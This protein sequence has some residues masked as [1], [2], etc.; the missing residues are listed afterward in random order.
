MQTIQ[1]IYS[2]SIRPLG[3]NER[4][5]L[6]ALILE[7]VTQG[8]KSSQL[9]AEEKTLARQRLRQFAGTVAGGNPNA[10]DNEQIDKDLALEYLNSH[11]DET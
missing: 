6:A 1:E 3:E 7:D 4:L 10:S 5:R 8:R 11:E 2:K 9:T